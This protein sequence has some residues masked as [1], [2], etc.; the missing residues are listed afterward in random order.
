MKNTTRAAIAA[1]MILSIVAI[2]LP[3]ATA[4]YPT[5][6][7][8]HYPQMPPGWETGQVTGRVTTQKTTEGIGGAYVSIVNAS[9]NNI[10]YCN[11]TADS[12]GY[13]QFTDVNAT[14]GDNSY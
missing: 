5:S 14:V 12:L 1:T 8:S 13:Y 11:D 2:L 6:F 4:S 9:N 3:V 7:G 10:E